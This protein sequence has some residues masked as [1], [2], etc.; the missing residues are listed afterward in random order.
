MGANKL[1]TKVQAPGSMSLRGL[2]LIIS[3][4]GRQSH[5]G[6]LA[7][8]ARFTWRF[9]QASP[10]VKNLISIRSRSRFRGRSESSTPMLRRSASGLAQRVS[11]HQR[12]GLDTPV[13]SSSSGRRVQRDS[14]G[15]GVSPMAS[16][17]EPPVIL[18]C[19]P[20]ALGGQA[21]RSWRVAGLVGSKQAPDK[22]V[23]PGKYEFPGPTVDHR[24]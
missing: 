23:G 2:R 19:H 7:L 4:E 1:R 9:Q 22:G 14:G 17:P 6:S 10:L 15:I 24:R 20:A 12:V 11:R 21:G 16:A 5:G 8:S 3:N 18:R 13:Q